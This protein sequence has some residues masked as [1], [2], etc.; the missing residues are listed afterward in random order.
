[1]KRPELDW[2]MGVIKTLGRWVLIGHMAMVQC[3][4]SYRAWTDN[5][6]QLGVAEDPMDQ[7]VLVGLGV[8]LL[9]RCWWYV[10]ERKG[11]EDE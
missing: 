1:M 4:I 2:A 6:P 8:L 7:W 10:V 5:D 9:E 3:L 11:K